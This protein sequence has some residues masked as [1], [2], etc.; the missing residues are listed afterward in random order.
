MVVETYGKLLIVGKDGKSELE[1]PLDKQ[2]I[3][4]GR[5]HACDIRI[6]NKEISRKHAELYTESN[7]SVFI[8]SMG[9]EPVSVNGVP[10]VSPVE[11][12][13]GDKIE[14]HLEGRTRIFYF[15][16]NE[17]TLQV[18]GRKPLKDLNAASMKV[19]SPLKPAMSSKRND[20]DEDEGAMPSSPPQDNAQKAVEEPSAPA[21]EA[22]IQ[23]EM[24]VEEP[25]APVSVVQEEDPSAGGGGAAPLDKTE[26]LPAFEAMDQAQNDENEDEQPLIDAT[27]KV[28]FPMEE[29]I[30]EAEPMM[31]DTT[32]EEIFEEEDE[33]SEE[34][35]TAQLVSCIVPKAIAAAAVLAENPS[36]VSSEPEIGNDVGEMMVDEE[37]NENVQ[38]VEADNPALVQNEGCVPPS[39]SQKAKKS[40]RF[41]AAATGTPEGAAYDVAGALSFNLTANSA[42]DGVGAVVVVDDNTIA[43]AQWA[44][45]ASAFGD[46]EEEQATSPAANKRATP[47]ASARAPD[48]LIKAKAQ[49]GQFVQK[50]IAAAVDASASPAPAG[51]RRQSTAPDTLLK[52][53]AQVSKFVSDAIA[54]AADAAATPASAGRRQS[55]APDT[56]LKAKAQ[57]SKFVSEAIAAATAASPASAYRR[58]SGAPNTLVK[59]KAHV[60]QFVSEAIEAAVAGCATPQTGALAAKLTELEQEHD[61]TFELPADFMRWTPALATSKKILSIAVAINPRGEEV[62]KNA[63]ATTPAVATCTTLAPQ[64]LAAKLAELQQEHDITFELPVDFMRWT[65]APAAVGRK[66]IAVGVTPRS[67]VAVAAAKAATP[68]MAGMTPAGPGAQAPAPTPNTAITANKSAAR[69]KR[70]MS[71]DPTSLAAKLSE[72]ADEH[73]VDFELPADFMRWTPAAKRTVSISV[74]PR[75]VKAPSSVAKSQRSVPRSAARGPAVTPAK[76]MTPAGPGAQA[77]AT[78]PATAAKSIGRVTMPGAVNLPVDTTALATKL[79]ALA[80]QHEVTFELPA[81]FMRWTPAPG[82]KTSGN[83]IIAPVSAMKSQQ[84]SA[85]RSRM[86]QAV[87]YAD[88]NEVF[89]EDAMH[90][91]AEENDNS[92]EGFGSDLAASLEA[93]A[94]ARKTTPMSKSTAPGSLSC[95]RRSSI[96]TPGTKIAIIGRSTPRSAAPSSVK[97]VRTTAEKKRQQEYQ[98]EQ[99]DI[100]MDIEAAEV[101]PPPAAAEVIEKEASGETLEKMESPEIEIDNAD[102]LVEEMV[103]QAEEV[104]E[105]DDDED[106][107]FVEE[108]G[109]EEEAAGLRRVAFV[110]L[111]DYRR[112][113]VQ[114]RIHRSKATGLATQLRGVSARALRLK[115]A[116]SGLAKALEEERAKRQELQATLQRIVANRE[117]EEDED[118]MDCEDDDDQEEASLVSPVQAKVVVI[119]YNPAPQPCHIELAGNV[120]VVRPARNINTT[121]TPAKSP[122]KASVGF[123]AGTIAKTPTGGNKTATKSKTPGTLK[124][125]VGKTPAGGRVLDDVEVPSWVFETETAGV[126]AVDVSA[127]LAEVAAAEG[128]EAR[129]AAALK[130][131]QADVAAQAEAADSEEEEVE[132]EEAEGA[133]FCH[134]CNEGEE[135]DVLLLCDGC[136][137]ACHLS[138]CNPPLRRVPKGDWFCVDCKKAKKA[139]EAAAKNAPAAGGGRGK[140]RA[141]A[142]EP[143]VAEEKK[144]APARGKK[145]PEKPAAGTKRGRGAAASTSQDEKAPAA[146]RTRGGRQ[147]APASNEK[148]AATKPTTRTRK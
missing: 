25:I 146:K 27:E 1:F 97:N 120:V 23:E 78:T 87:D 131:L 138:C 73:D 112:A 46:A 7:G 147:A 76:G 98:E 69:A 90:P 14:V 30:M 89:P 121:T 145:A 67:A 72:L 20:V 64:Q 107:D 68:A 24:A 133:D 58:Q 17:D 129:D 80:E 28:E 31:M 59:A 132:E 148:P 11:L 45:L 70:T 9:R 101:A 139:E 85:G 36:N 32:E 4:I 15:H 94:S 55:T 10:V 79:A 43:F 136:E 51:G 16:S 5:D 26:K 33:K 29:E 100:M 2:N 8:N 108:Q 81:D 109:A 127:E 115:R 91:V 128:A 123:T 95:R 110:S 53:K 52:A 3:L 82:N 54:A 84:R 122:T 118:V 40:V 38:E 141:A 83:V 19:T 61:I 137:N 41:T 130:K 135:G 134:K 125:T 62:H 96:R 144:A 12:S 102:I 65:P 35:N 93:V 143:D 66:A 124:K 140:K 56:L 105:D 117:A 142:S 75:T 103:G 119:G 106:F 47:N 18:A 34:E 111:A 6:V 21:A 57:V 39:T 92:G 88:N 44:G 42:G 71:L 49:V 48:T 104:E 116:A 77:P 50:A 63:A 37:E 22:A 126:P 113:V 13:T 99:K 86:A 114:V 60:A 74:T